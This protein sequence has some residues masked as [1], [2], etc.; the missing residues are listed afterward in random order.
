MKMPDKVLTYRIYNDG[1]ELIGTASVQMPS[2]EYLTETAK[3]AGIMGE[4]DSPAIG[5][6][7]SLTLA[8]NFK[9]V[10]KGAINLLK[11]KAHALELR[12]AQQVFDSSIGSYKMQPVKIVTR[13]IPKKVDLGK[14]EVAAMTDSALELEVTYLK[15]YIDGE[16]ILEID[17]FNYVFF[18]NGT[19]Y[20]EE[21]QKALG[22]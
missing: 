4:V 18:I 22:L 21:I 16:R 10:E 8:L 5:Q 13:A 17:K 15:I 19:D 12:A 3:G 14:L 9:T 20:G 6:V 2:I 11:P 1:K 7:G